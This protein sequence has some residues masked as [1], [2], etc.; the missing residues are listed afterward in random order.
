MLGFRSHATSHSTHLD[1]CR[2]LHDMWTRHIATYKTLSCV[3]RRIATYTYKTLSC[4]TFRRQHTCEILNASS[5][6]SDA[7]HDTRY[8]LMPQLKWHLSS[9]Y[10][11]VAC[12][13]LACVPQYH[14]QWYCEVAT[15]HFI[16]YCEVATPLRATSRY[17]HDTNVATSNVA[18]PLHLCHE[19]TTKWYSD[20]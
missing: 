17:S 14:T 3:T 13:E 4:V 1:V 5:W 10:H 15:F 19:N 18:T 8:S 2:D 6:H 11:E 20:D 9:E 16:W 7:C 12:H